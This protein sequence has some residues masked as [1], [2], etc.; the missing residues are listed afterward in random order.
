MRDQAGRSLPDREAGE[1]SS[2][3]QMGESDRQRDPEEKALPYV[4]VVAVLFVLAVVVII[5]TR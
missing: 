3:R 1:A 4:L 2:T 5:A